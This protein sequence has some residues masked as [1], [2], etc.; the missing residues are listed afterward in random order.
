MFL[1]QAGRQ[2]ERRRTTGAGNNAAVVDVDQAVEE[3]VPMLDGV[4]QRDRRDYGQ[5]E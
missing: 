5:R 3:I 2:I 4:P 1:D